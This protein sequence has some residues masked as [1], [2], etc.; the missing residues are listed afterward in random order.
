MRKQCKICGC[1]LDPG[2]WCDCDEHE[3]PEQEMAKRPV[4]RRKWMPTQMGEEQ[5]VR[6]LWYEYDLQ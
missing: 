2:E 3:A 5:N 4:S 6:R 1:Y